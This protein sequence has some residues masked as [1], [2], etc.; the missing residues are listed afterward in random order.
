MKTDEEIIYF[1]ESGNTEKGIK[2]AAQLFIT[3]A[4]IQSTEKSCKAAL[5]K[6]F[7]LNE[8]HEIKYND[9]GRDKDGV[10][11]ALSAFKESGGRVKTYC[12]Y[13]PLFIFN[14][15]LTSFFEDSAEYIGADSLS[16][17]PDYTY[18][19]LHNYWFHYII[20]H[21][22]DFLADLLFAY[23]DLVFD[24]NQDYYEKLRELTKEK[25]EMGCLVTKMIFTS[26]ERNKLKGVQELLE[27]KNDVMG[28]RLLWIDPVF[29]TTGNLFSRW[30]SELKKPL[31]VIHDESYPLEKRTKLIKFIT[32]LGHISPIQSE[33]DPKLQFFLHSYELKEL[34]FA[35]SEDFYGLQVADLLAG[36][37]NEVAKNMGPNASQEIKT[38]FESLIT[39]IE[40][41]NFTHMF[42]D[43]NLLD[44]PLLWEI[45]W[46]CPDHFCKQ[47]I[48]KRIKTKA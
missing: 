28:D 7:D 38:Y 27:T 39:I 8:S 32:Q 24:M 15:L 33:I 29:C 36:Y 44:P 20:L 42:P 4:S 40:P 6:G 1:D 3:F 47:A 26:L 5:S 13:K 9:V 25:A 19:R 23:Q 37:V 21:G 18:W 16:G 14:S 11:K 10:V 35:K 30:H 43:Q 31:N 45:L 12:V 41:E 17:N 2:D 22:E 34:K 46:K 48:I